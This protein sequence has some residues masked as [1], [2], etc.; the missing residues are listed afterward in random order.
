MPLIIS[1][2]LQRWDAPEE[3]K[4]LIA[5]TCAR[6][7]GLEQAINVK[8]LDQITALHQKDPRLAELAVLDLATILFKPPP[9]LGQLGAGA[10]IQLPQHSSSRPLS[11]AAPEFTPSRPGTASPHDNRDLITETISH[12]SKGFKLADSQAPASAACSGPD[13]PPCVQ[14]W[15][16]NAQ[17]GAVGWS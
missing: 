2:F 4:V 7:A 16:G 15:G 10:Q 3:L 12:I 13:V 5:A 9:T 6:T 17:V 1:P 14:Y 11:V 8:H